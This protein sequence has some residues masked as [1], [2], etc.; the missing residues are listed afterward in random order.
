MSNMRA[1]VIRKYGGPEVFEEAE[2]PRPEAGEGQVRLKVTATSFNPIES[3]IRVGIARLGPEFPAVLN[4]DVAGVIDQVGPGVTGF[5]E[6][7]EVFALSGGIQGSPG[8]LAEYTLVDA[9]LLA[10]KPKAL[11][12][13]EC[14]ALPIGFITAWYA[15]CRMT[16]IRAGQT[17]LVLGGTGGVGHVG[18]QL[19]RG[20][21][22]EVYATVSSDEKAQVV[23]G[24][25]ACAAIDR[26]VDTPEQYVDTHTGGKGF[27]FVFDTAG[28]DSLDNAFAAAR[29]E[30]QVATVNA[31]ANHDLTPAHVRGLSLHLV[32]ILRSMLLGT[33][34]EHYGQILAEAARLADEG[35]L[36][37]LMDRRSFSVWEV[38]EAHRYA[39]TGATIG[40]I[41]LTV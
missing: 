5:A 19:A 3:K 32:M 24:L 41:S 26:R 14:A 31:R 33:D 6:G 17:V 9:R 38:A 20:L 12:L 1:M 37:P 28:G 39:E 2:I 30:G 40:K 16:Q 27:D 18:V 8:A 36:R 29:Y 25:G 10:R 11:S 4:S 35:R 34:L 15:L 13:A 23:R 22:A 7:D 21:G